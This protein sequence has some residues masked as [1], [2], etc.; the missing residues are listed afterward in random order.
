MHVNYLS[1]CLF[2]I[3]LFVAFLFICLLLFLFIYLLFY[4]EP[5]TIPSR[6]KIVPEVGVSE[7]EFSANCLPVKFQDVKF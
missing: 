7:E 6:K 1:V 3:C 5:T 2:Y 4:Q